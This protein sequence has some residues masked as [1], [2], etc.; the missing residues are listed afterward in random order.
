MNQLRKWFV[1]ICI[2]L[3]MLILTFIGIMGSLGYK[4]IEANAAYILFG[5]LIALCLGKLAFWITGKV[6]RKSWRLFTGL[7][8]TLILA[9]LMTL[10]LTFFIFVNQFYTAR[11]FTVLESESGRKVV[12]MRQISHQYAFDR[13]A[14]SPKS[15]LQFEDLGYSYQIYPVFSKFFYNSKLP[16][17]GYLEIG[18][19][20]SATL[21]HRWEGDS[22]HMYIENPE[23]FDLGELTFD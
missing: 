12:V 13:A 6:Q 10:L 8:C 19:A 17:E 21:M 22:L 11:Q 4:L 18:C 7:I 1:P 20:S 9:G 3:L 16:A 14:D 5:L 2:G 15:A 23:E